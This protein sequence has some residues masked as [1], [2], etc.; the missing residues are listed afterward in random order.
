M[1]AE[2]GH[3]SLIL[4]LACAV[5]RAGASIPVIVPREGPLLYFFWK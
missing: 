1:T 4:A 2:I 5:Y 3:G